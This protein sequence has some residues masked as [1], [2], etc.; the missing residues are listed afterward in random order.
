MIEL[1]AVERREARR[2]LLRFP[3]GAW[4]VFDFSGFINAA[5]GMTLP[6]SDEAFFASHFI[7]AGELHRGA[8]AA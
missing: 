5:T 3:D 2:L 4:G 8:S 7:E 6:L 1:I